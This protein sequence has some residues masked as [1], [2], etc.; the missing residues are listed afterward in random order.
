MAGLSA[1]MSQ[2]VCVLCRKPGILSSR[3]SQCAPHWPRA[4][5][6]AVDR[7]AFARYAA[8]VRP[9]MPPPMTITS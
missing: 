3:A 5:K 7:P 4:S 6:T 8:A 9:L 1:G 2:T